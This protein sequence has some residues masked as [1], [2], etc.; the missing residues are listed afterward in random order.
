[1]LLKQL[2]RMSLLTFSLLEFICFAKLKKY[3]MI[4][5]A[6]YD[7]A[8][9]HHN[10]DKVTQQA[11]TTKCWKSEKFDEIVMELCYVLHLNTIHGCLN[12]T[13]YWTNYF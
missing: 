8:H 6:L 12:M 5:I 10:A 9:Q 13:E 2:L 7:F 3:K 4:G 1:M 11:K